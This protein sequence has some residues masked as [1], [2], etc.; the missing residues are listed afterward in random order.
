MSKEKLILGT[1]G[2]DLALTQT[3][4]VE[5]IL[6]AAH[7]ALECETK[8]ISTI[9]DERQDLK[10][11][12][13]A[14][15]QIVDKGIFTKELEVALAAGEVDVAVHSL[16]DVPTQL[17]VEFKL[18]AVLPREDTRDALL[19]KSACTTLAELPKSANLATSS[20]RRHAQLQW[21]RADLQI[22]EIRGNV[23]TRIGK[24]LQ[25]PSLDGLLLA[26]AGLRRLGYIGEGETEFEYEGQTIYVSPL[27]PPDFLPACGQGAIALETRAADAGTDAILALIND[28]DT[29]V[30][31]DAERM[32]LDRLQ[33]GCHTPV[34]VDTWL[35]GE[36]MSIHLRVFD[37]N[38]LTATPKEA[39]VSGSRSDVVA[40]VD[41]VMDSLK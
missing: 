26:L 10:L 13:F 17:D 28:A 23:P 3:R 41:Q 5:A 19:T 30:R 11:T 6:K 14:K 7:P 37:E 9:G 16:K 18:E 40:L 4:M 20:V 27:A 31:I 12:E 38:D 35:N 8:I 33:A 29:Y 39:R 2:S 15:E 36:E 25:N 21:L 32:I 22:E 1:R 34:G 24:L